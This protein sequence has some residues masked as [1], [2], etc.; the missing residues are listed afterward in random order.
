MN[1]GIHNH[2]RRPLWLALLATAVVAIAPCSQ[3]TALAG[4][5]EPRVQAI[6]TK[7]LDWVASTQSRLGH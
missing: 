4:K 7:G 6:V 1:L 3:R 5:P 2:R